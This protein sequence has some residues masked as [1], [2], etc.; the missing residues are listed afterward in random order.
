MKRF[1][2]LL[3]LILA[4][5]SSL[6][7]PISVDDGIQ[8]KPRA[9]KPTVQSGKRALYFDSISSTWQSTDGTTNTAIGSSYT[10]PNCLYFPPSSPTHVDFGSVYTPATQFGQ[11][12]FEG[13]LRWDSGQY[14][15]SDG[16]GGAHAWLFGVDPVTRLLTGNFYDN[17]ANHSFGSED[18]V[19]SGEWF[20][21]AVGY[22]GVAI[23]VY[24]N[25]V[26]SGRVAYTGQR[27][28]GSAGSAGWYVGGS[29]H[30]NFYGCV[31]SM[32]LFE[33]YCPTTRAAFRPNRYFGT[34][35]GLVDAYSA[36]KWLADFT[37][38]ASII[39]DLGFVG[40]GYG[41]HP[42][43]LTNAAPIDS[44]TLPLYKEPIPYWIYDPNSPVQY[45]SAPQSQWGAATL[46]PPATPAGARFF[47]SFSRADQTFATEVGS[48][49]G[50]GTGEG[51]GTLGALSWND[52][53]GYFGIFKGRVFLRTLAQRPWAWV[54]NGLSDMDVSVDRRNGS[55]GDVGLVLRFVDASNYTKVWYHNAI[56]SG[57]GGDNH[58]RVSAVE[59]GVVTA[60]VVNAVPTASFVTLRAKV[61]TVG[62][63]STYTVYTDGNQI[64][65]G[66]NEANAT[67]TKAGI[68]TEWYTSASY[69]NA[70]GRMDNFT[71]YATP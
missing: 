29:D 44:T 47:D 1:S 48:F 7:K 32:R 36:I 31:A 25:G 56:P 58:I 69:A 17:S 18:Q 20:H 43:R 57:N 71:I 8:A 16:Y 6:A 9:T 54:E 61:K 46:T 34:K 13:W 67:G 51:T 5:T 21:F 11:S 39:A 41:N 10:A 68:Y 50:L 12:F 19:V 4:S 65:T 64:G 24:I 52:P 23:E 66:T 60:D 70:H 38:P 40:V 2:L 35:F 42:G 27:W 33:G 22:N 15:L 49:V 37:K 3:A 53:N 14:F 26:P 59:G 28:S 62:G 30:Q 55:T 63:V 45:P